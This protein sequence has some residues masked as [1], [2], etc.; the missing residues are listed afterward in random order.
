MRAVRIILVTAAAAALLITMVR[1]P[2]DSWRGR[3]S[4]GRRRR[5]SGCSRSRSSAARCGCTTSRS[6]SATSATRSSRDGDALT[7]TSDFDF[8]DRGGRVQLAA[9]LRTKA[10]FTPLSFKASGKSYR[11]V[12]VDS[13]VRIEGGD[14]IVKADGAESRV[15][16][17]RAV[18]HRRRLRAVR[19][20][21]DAAALLEAARPAARDAH[22][23]GTARQRRLHRGAR[24]RG[25]PDRIDRGAA[26]ALRDR[27]R[28]LGTRDGVARRARRARRG[29]HAR[30]RT[31]LRG[32][33]RGSRAG[34]GRV[35][36]ARRRAIASPISRRSRGACQPLKSG[37]YAM[38]GATIVDGTGRPP[39]AERRDRG[40]RRADRRGRTARVGRRFRRTCRRSRSTARRS[41][42]GCGTCTRTSRRSSGRRSTLAPA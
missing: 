41:S 16:A 22:R 3:A 42:P 27:R 11:F 10:D 9:T 12:N 1:L 34:A 25:D 2:T 19:G 7:L 37:T 36:P 40:A 29:D 17:A 23:A 39:I 6:R 30:R 38:V 15:A 31:E 20:A 13:E 5:A 35:R 26:R 14:A 4:S 8:T 18:L 28:R 33:A 32:G 24:P 21:D